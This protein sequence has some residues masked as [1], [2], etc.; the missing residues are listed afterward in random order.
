MNGVDRLKRFYGLW[1]LIIILVSGLAV[2]GRGYATDGDGAGLKLRLEPTKQIYSNHEGLVM[3]FIFMAQSKTKLCLDKDIL[4]QMQ[5]TIAQPGQGKIPLKP[6]VLTDN[7][8]IFQ[9]PMKVLW[10]EA[11]DSVTLRANLKRFQFDGGNQWAPG[12]YSVNAVFNLCEQTP[13]EVVT[14]PGKEI[15]VKSTGQGWFMIMI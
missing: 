6:L 14:D 5:I 15:P 13:A 8:Q 12:E 7:S 10:L 11:G 3:K 4:S 2:A 1:L 9:E